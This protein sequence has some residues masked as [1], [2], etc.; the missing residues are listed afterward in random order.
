M[1]LRP[2][3]SKD[4]YSI[5]DAERASAWERL[6]LRLKLT[7]KRAS[8]RPSLLGILF[9][10]Y[11]II[12]AELF[13]AVRELSQGACG[14]VL[15]VG[16]GSKP[17]RELFPHASSY[18]GCDV[19]GG[20]HDHALS[21]VD[22]YFDGNALP[23]ADASHDWVVSFETLEHVFEPEA[24]LREFNRVTRP[25]GRLLISVPFCWD[26]H[27]I[28]NDFG[29]YT[30]YGLQQVLEKNGFRVVRYIKT[31]NYVLALSQ[32]AMAY[33]AQHLLPRNRYLKLALNPFVITPLWFIARGLNRILPHHDELFLNS[34]VL[35]RKTA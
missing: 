24:M 20:S 13:K 9:N 34:V 6:L 14:R 10:P 7:L 5:A 30:S 17:Y 25:D 15:D 11:Q 1:L 26:E 19:R 8:F 4:V 16:C 2:L 22:R 3:L 27:E 32:L 33:I 35:C 28:P 18:V 31:G 29:R 23:F 21:R 12:R